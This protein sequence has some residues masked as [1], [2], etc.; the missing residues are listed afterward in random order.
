MSTELGGVQR[1]R[2]WYGVMV[3]PL[4]WGAQ[5]LFGVLLINEVCDGRGP[6]PSVRTALIAAGIIGVALS[7][8]GG[9]MGWRTWRQLEPDGRFLL[10]EGKERVQMMSLMGVYSGVVFSIGALW[11]G[12]PS[13]MLLRLCEAV[14]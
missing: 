13:L 6:H 5:N 9:L 11:S 7:I 10:A 4:A 14:R 3:P 12:L 2:L 1:W 8:S